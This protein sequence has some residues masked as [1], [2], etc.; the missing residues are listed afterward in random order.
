MKTSDAV[1]ERFKVYRTEIDRISQDDRNYDEMC[2][3]EIEQ[4]EADAELGRKLKELLPDL[5][6]QAK[7]KCWSDNKG[8]EINDCAGGNIDDAYW[9][10]DHDG[11]ICRVRSILKALGEV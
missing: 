4:L 1:R 10:G 6:E 5:R 2:I 3:A 11:D 8:W 7:E 9:G